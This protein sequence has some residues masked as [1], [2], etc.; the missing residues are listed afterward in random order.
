VLRAEDQNAALHARSARA[1]PA[2]GAE[3]RGTDRWSFQP[4]QAH[5]PP[6]AGDPAWALNPIDGFIWEKL[7]QA[8]LEPSSAADR[9][10]LIR[11]VYYEMC[12][13]PPAPEAVQEF[14]ADERPDAWER[15]VDRVLASPRYGERWAGHWLDVVR[16]GESDGFETN[17]ERPS[18]YRYRDYVI[19][20]FNDDKPYDRFVAEQLAG[21]A[22]GADPATGFLVAGPCDVVKSPDVQ[23]TLMQRQDELADIIHTTGTTFLGL[24][25]GCARCHDHKFDP[26]TQKDYYAL[27]AVF[28]GVIH[29]E[30]E[31]RDAPNIL[32]GK[33]QSPEAVKVYAGIFQQPQPTHLLFRGDPLEPRQQVAPDT[34]AVLD[35]L[36]LSAEAPEQARRRAL[37]EW[38]VR[39]ENPLAARVLAN[40]IWHC[41]FAQGIVATPNDFGAS[42]A[43]PT[44]PELLD[45]LAS[46]LV[47]G[48]WSVKRLHRLILL[49]QT[50]RQTS[51]PRD[52]GV[53]VD[54]GSRLLWRF[55]PRRLEAEA[56]RDSVLHVSGVLDLKIGDRGFLG[57][58]VIRENVFHYFPKE[59]FGP[60]DW[61]RMIY[62]IK[63]R[64]ENEDVFGLFDC[65]DGGQVVPK[66]S[67]STTALQALNLLNSK[68]MIQQADLFAARLHREA[69]NDPMPQI[70]RAFLLAFGRKPNDVELEASLALVQQECL[71]AVCL[72]LFNANEFLFIP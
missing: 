23:L 39:P 42:G 55:P 45:W 32:S 62:M 40:R 33:N 21:D 29:G 18:A 68:F 5:A 22:L 53:N 49:S 46:Q 16:F 24:T 69:G 8:G 44:H 63:I 6:R 56:I 59:E 54:A 15:L 20:A 57:L 66:R 10:T 36:E 2:I 60:Q 35:S 31:W 11:R 58:N 4:I 1:A 71:S 37:A 67:R 25:L 13:L 26:V 48:G 34:I 27:Q 12:G 47:R 7:A 28:A 14:V 30:R 17:R 61:R 9:V 51:A 52:D 19:D 50:Y 38:L 72:A 43:A 3:A 70:Q 64:K 41:H 65:P